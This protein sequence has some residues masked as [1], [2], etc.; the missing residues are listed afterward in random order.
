M[1]RHLYLRSFDRRLYN[2]PAG[3][4]LLRDSSFQERQ[5]V[6]HLVERDGK[7]A[8]AHAG[9][10]EHRIGHGRGG[11]ADAEFTDALDAKNV[12]FAVEAVEQ[13]GI[14]LGDVG[15]H[16]YQVLRDVRAPISGQIQQLLLRGIGLKHI[17]LVPYR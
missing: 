11:A 14:D 8:R 9:G 5:T 6:Q 13:Y 10:I 12:G 7:I 17:P 3:A 15:M 4:D 16:G 1:R 2:E